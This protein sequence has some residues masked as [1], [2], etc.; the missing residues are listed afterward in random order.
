MV[1]DKLKR[2][3]LL[4][5]YFFSTIINNDT[6]TALNRLGN[7]LITFTQYSHF[8]TFI[9]VQICVC[10]SL[11][12]IFFMSKI[13]ILKIIFTVRYQTQLIFKNVLLTIR[14][15]LH[16]L[17]IQVT[18]SLK[19]EEINWYVHVGNIARVIISTK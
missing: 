18:N 14:P 12:F 6:I 10:I 7:W 2:K 19:L 17:N 16:W 15:L 3:F 1:P 4:I 13:E 9:K 5:C 8:C 11:F